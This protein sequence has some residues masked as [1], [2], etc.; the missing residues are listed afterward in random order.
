M[1]TM[2]NLVH[3]QARIGHGVTAGEG[4]QIRGRHIGRRVAAAAPGA[5]DISTAKGDEGDGSSTGSR[6]AEV[7]GDKEYQ[8][9]RVKVIRLSRRS[10]GEPSVGGYYLCRWLEVAWMRARESG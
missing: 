7:G 10:R 8:G 4:R 2:S 5:D 6:L 1:I 3:G 9:R